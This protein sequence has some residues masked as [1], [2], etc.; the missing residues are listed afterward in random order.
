M[1]GCVTSPFLYTVSYDTTYNT[2]Y[3]GKSSFE[4][5]TSFSKQY[6][7]NGTI[8]N[9]SSRSVVPTITHQPN[10]GQNSE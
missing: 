5:Q 6:F 7:Q 1:D 2:I 10:N 3:N 4:K 8:H 9:N